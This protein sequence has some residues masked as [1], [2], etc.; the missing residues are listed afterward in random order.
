MEVCAEVFH[1]L[2]CSNPKQGANLG[3]TPRK[4]AADGKRGSVCP[5]LWRE[6]TLNADRNLVGCCYL[7]LR[8]DDFGQ[9]SENLL[10]SVGKAVSTPRPAGFSTAPIWPDCRRALVH[11]CLKCVL[12]HRQPHLKAC[13]EGTRCAILSH[14]S[15]WNQDHEPQGPNM[16][17]KGRL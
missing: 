9:I 11:T 16:M 15:G 10:G 14:L 7:Y 17:G 4:L 5:H 2:D 8:Q 1:A 6:V 12:V 13:P 3:G